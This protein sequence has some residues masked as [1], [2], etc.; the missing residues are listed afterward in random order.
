MDGINRPAGNQSNGR[1]T[2]ARFDISLHCQVFRDCAAISIVV[3]DPAHVRIIMNVF[4][5]ATVRTSELFYNHARSVEAIHII[6]DNVLT[7]RRGARLSEK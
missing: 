6:Q 1:W 2:A 7:L 4:G 5:H 3:S